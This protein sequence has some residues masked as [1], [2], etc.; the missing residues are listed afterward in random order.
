MENHL[1]FGAF[2]RVERQAA[3]SRHKKHLKIQ[4]G[5]NSG[6]SVYP[7]R[8]MHKLD[9]HT[10]TFCS[11]TCAPDIMI[12]WKNLTNE[13]FKLANLLNIHRCKTFRTTLCAALSIQHAH[14]HTHTHTKCLTK[15]PIA[16]LTW[17]T[18]SEVYSWVHIDRRNLQKGSSP[19]GVERSSWGWPGVLI[20]LAA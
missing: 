17:K 10:N 5:S 4:S 3:Q 11:T 12:S 14:T 19:H 18:A 6:C 1:F 13:R 2:W 7:Q 20:S 8:S 9:S 15:T 16:K